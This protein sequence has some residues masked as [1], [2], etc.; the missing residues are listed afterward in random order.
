MDIDTYRLQVQQSLSTRFGAT[1]VERPLFSRIAD[2]R[3]VLTARLHFFDGSYLSLRERVDTERS[4]P[5]HIKYSYHY[6]SQGDTVFRYDNSTHYPDV[7][8][9][10][11]HK[12]VGPKGKQKIVAAERPSFRQ[13]AREIQAQLRREP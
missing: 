7:S 9:H 5:R 12:H 8:S 11:A 1:G 13:L 10:P 3:A 4:Y 6:V 2:N